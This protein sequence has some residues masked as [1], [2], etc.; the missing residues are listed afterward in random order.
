MSSCSWHNHPGQ[1][2]IRLLKGY[3][4]AGTQ[5]LAFSIDF[6]RRPFTTVLRTTVPQ[7]DNGCLACRVN[8]LIRII[9]CVCTLLLFSPVI[10]TLATISSHTVEQSLF[11]ADGLSCLFPRIDELRPSRPE[12]TITLPPRSIKRNSK[13]NQI[14]HHIQPRRHGIAKYAKTSD[15]NPSLYSQIRENLW[16]RIYS[17][18]FH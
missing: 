18:D 3:G 8:P 14:P 5:S 2:L 12:S 6:D 13:I 17:G 7:R 11:D 1:I 10:T 4:T 9:L 16:S 15:Y